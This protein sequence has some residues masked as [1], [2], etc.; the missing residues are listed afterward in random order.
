[1]WERGAGNPHFA[2]QIVA[3]WLADGLLL[4]KSPLRWGL[5][6]GVDVDDSLPESVE[7]LSRSR[8]DGAL[9]RAPD[10]A[11]TRDVLHGAALVGGPV[12]FEALWAV[13]S[14]LGIDD[15]PG[16]RRAWSHLHAE[17]LLATRSGL[18]G[19]DHPLLRATVLRDVGERRD[20]AALHEACAEGL[21]AWSTSAG[22]DLRGE[23]AEH[24]LAAGR[25]DQALA[26]LLTAARAAE[27]RDVYRAI[28]L[29]RSAL[30]ALESMNT[31][32][33]DPRRV[34]ILGG[35]GFT[36]QLLGDLHQ[37]EKL[38]REGLGLSG[39]DVLGA[40]VHCALAEVMG[41]RGQLDE[42]LSL[43]AQA[44][45]ILDG[46][47]DCEEVRRCRA[48]AFRD[49]AEVLVNQDEVAQAVLFLSRSIR[50]ASRAGADDEA[51]NSRW[52]LARTRRIMGELAASRTEFEAALHQSLELG[53]RRIEAICLRE[54]GNLALM[55]GELER[56]RALYQDTL[57]LN[58]AGGHELERLATENSLAE[59]ARRAG[60]LDAAR[61]G[62][63]S[64]LAIARANSLQ[65]ECAVA[66]TNLGLTALESGRPAD[67]LRHAEELAGQLTDQPAHWLTPFLLVIE[68]AAYAEQGDWPRF[69]RVAGEIDRAD[70]AR[71]PD[72]DLARWLTHAADRAELQ[73]Q[74]AG[75]LR[76]QAHRIAEALTS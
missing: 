69:A 73:G 16:V 12:D 36:S 59:L 74:H 64:A 22:R 23:I 57:A 15:R 52:K 11:L 4:E 55:D 54:L 32:A 28:R 51:L 17:G 10:R 19:L 9:R 42:A 3:S 48:R 33:E 1:V 68:A 71:T 25:P 63:R 56:A 62:Y 38:L 46:L 27:A 45:R 49:H 70:L 75:S 2:V 61:E 53:D 47:D 58:R 14:A 26:D 30:G 50:E 24:L 60:D 21:R 34:R 67:A 35:L 40:S 37:A 6:P 8:I 72:P 7:G 31:P 76:Q 5:R 44:S 41:M 66:L 13:L 43:T 29:Y 18:T 65:V 39:A 20:V